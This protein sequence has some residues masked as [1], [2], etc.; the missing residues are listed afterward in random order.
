MRR[1]GILACALGVVAAA[2]SDGGGGRPSRADATTTTV[3]TSGAGTIEL[4]ARNISFDRT[5]LATG[6]GTVTFVYDNRDRGIPHNLHVSGPG[7]D[8]RTSIEPGPVRQRLTLRLPPGSYTYICDV[9][10]QQMRGRLT[11]S[12]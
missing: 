2:C 6:T 1:L 9:H 11:V 8:Q 3:G 7:I 12:G 5:S 4:V 10:P